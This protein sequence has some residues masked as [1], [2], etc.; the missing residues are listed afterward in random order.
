V[1]PPYRVGKPFEFLI[2]AIYRVDG[3]RYPGTD[4]RLMFFHY[5]YLDEATRGRSGAGS[6]NI[7]IDDPQK[8][9]TVAKAIDDLFENSDRQTKTETEAAFRAG[10]ASLAG[11]LAVLLNSIALAVTFT[12]L[13]VTANT[14]SMAVRERRTEIAVLK[15]LGF[16]SRLVMGLVMGEAVV[17]GMLGGALGIL[18]GAGMIR[19][20]PSIPMIGDAVRQ[21]PNLG[22][23]PEIAALGFGISLVLGSAAGFVPALGAY[24]SRIT[25]ML[26]TV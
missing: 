13:L 7:E 9:G 6:Y 21:Y 26:R 12:I 14:M 22:L 17:M 16:P 10:F 23:S 2:S 5:K 4:G 18:L 1:I 8:A 15:T 24:R 3:V 20:L 25:D 19:I 11:N